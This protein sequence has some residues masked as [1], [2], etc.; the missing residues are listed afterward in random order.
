MASVA[1]SA[2][3]ILF[4]SRELDR[5]GKRRHTVDILNS[6]DMARLHSFTRPPDEGAH[7][8]HYAHPPHMTMPFG[9]E[10]AIRQGDY[11]QVNSRAGALEWAGGE[12]RRMQMTASDGAMTEEA[13]LGSNGGRDA[14]T[15][16]EFYDAERTRHRAQSPPPN[17]RLV[18]RGHG[19]PMS[20]F[21]AQEHSAAVHSSSHR[22]L[23]GL[24]TDQ[25]LENQLSSPNEI[26]QGSNELSSFPYRPLSVD[27]MNDDTRQSNNQNARDDELSVE[28]T[29]SHLLAESSS[30]GETN[31]PDPGTDRTERD[32]DLDSIWERLQQMRLV[33]LIFP[34]RHTEA[35]K[36]RFG[37]TK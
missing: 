18:P 25:T 5:R 27:S 24:P 7:F 36:K 11:G 32:R 13:L 17:H 15:D 1:V 29:P 10:G 4:L 19:V 12:D 37:H 28:V 20:P 16:S 23:T 21:Y 34:H 35:N 8:H 3:A 26:V 33:D 6:G 22:M 9:G 14:S 31:R 30:S 2:G